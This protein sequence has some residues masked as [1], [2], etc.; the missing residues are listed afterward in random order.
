MQAEMVNPGLS[1]LYTL[2]T[3]NSVLAIRSPRQVNRGAMSSLV[4][5]FFQF[6]RSFFRP[7]A[8]LEAEV[9]VLRQQLI[10]AKRR[11]PKRLVI[12]GVDRLILV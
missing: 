10:V 8:D 3:E 11:A 9:V 6:L 12:T 7:Q 2:S 4:R 1:V 5:P